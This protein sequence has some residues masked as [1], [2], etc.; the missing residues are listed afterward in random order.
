MKKRPLTNECQWCKMELHTVGVC[1]LLDLLSS[2]TIL[3]QIGADVKKVLVNFLQR[4]P[5]YQN[6]QHKIP[7]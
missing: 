1:V 5:A 7:A 2:T 3:S 4:N 6:K